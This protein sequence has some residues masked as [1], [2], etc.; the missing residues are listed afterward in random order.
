MEIFIMMKM[1]KKYFHI[2]WLAMLALI[3]VGMGSC[4]KDAEKIDD[5]GELVFNDS[6]PEIVGDSMLYG[7]SCDGTS[8]SVVVI[9]PFYGDPLTISTIDA[10]ESNRIIGKPEIGDWIGVMRD[11]EDSTVATMVI[12]LDELKGTWTYPVMPTMKAL[13]NMSRRAQRR[14]M[15]HI[16]DSIKNNFMIPREYGFTLKRSHN[17]RAVGRIMRSNSLEDDSPVV[18]P[19]VKNYIKWYMLNGRLVLVSGQNG[20]VPPG[21]QRKNKLTMDTLDFVS[22]S[23]DS[24]VLLQNGIRYGFHR[25]ENAME[26]NKAAQEKEQSR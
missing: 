21:G 15:A 22:L 3:V 13:Q 1:M 2:L 24:L 12:N 7:L 17:A 20:P 25:K 18:Y 8:D 19:E 4:K 6:V 23:N 5:E 11:R 10:K 14:M 16:D 9:W 26:A